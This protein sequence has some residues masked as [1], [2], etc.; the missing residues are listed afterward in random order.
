MGALNNAEL[1]NRLVT[2]VNSEVY[3]HYTT[4][5]EPIKSFAHPL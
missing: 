1:M 2:A 5:E 4:H 3:L